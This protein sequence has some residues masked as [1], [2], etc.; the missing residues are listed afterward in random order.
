MANSRFPMETAEHLIRR[1]ETALAK[2]NE[3]A[4]PATLKRVGGGATLTAAASRT[5]A[6]LARS[7]DRN[8]LALNAIAAGPDSLDAR[9][10]AMQLRT[11]TGE[12]AAD[13]LAKLLGPAP[14]A[15]P[16]LLQLAGSLD[17]EGRAA[18]AIRL[19]DAALPMAPDW[20]AGHQSLAQLRWQAGDPIPTRS[21]GEALARIPG[22]ELLWAAGLGTVVRTS[23]WSLFDRVSTEARGR[24]PA[25]QLIAMVCADGYSE[26]GRE[27]EAD[28]LFDRLAEVA[29]ADFDAAKMRHAMRYRRICD[30]IRLGE[31]AVATHGG[32]EC[33][34]WL[35][36]AWRLAGDP[37]S[38]WVHRGTEL[39]CTFDLDFF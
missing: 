3:A 33:W 19:I 14:P 1:V 39:I 23:D 10:M 34:A 38:D 13:E 9:L 32:G 35:G 36:A 11:E 6:A 24:F 17:M 5:L 30:A 26:M 16:Q 27:T 28:R 37:R 29:D 20:V 4:A 31:Q 12:A 2:D 15:G 8:D 22:H 7:I 25:S 21:F 18:E